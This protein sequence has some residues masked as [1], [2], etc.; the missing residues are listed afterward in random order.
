MESL[1]NGLGTKVIVTIPLT[2][3]LPPRVLEKH[4]D[5]EEK[6]K[7]L[8]IL[9]VE[10]HPD[11]N[12]SLTMLLELR[13][14]TVTSALTVATALEIASGQDFDLLLSDLGLPDGNAGEVMKVVA[15]RN[16]AIGVALSGFGMEQDFEMSRGYGFSHHLVKPVEVAR[17][18]E[19]LQSCSKR[20]LEKI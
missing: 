19:I 8:R 17:L 1:G 13:G 5:P 12:E 10:D 18:D 11:T 6:A 4:S 15:A 3:K 9:L 20:S 7:D 2:E 16:G 14:Y